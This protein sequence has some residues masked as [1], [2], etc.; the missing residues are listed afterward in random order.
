MI[1]YMLYEIIFVIMTLVVIFVGITIGIEALDDLK[2]AR[3]F[4]D[5]NKELK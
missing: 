1:H 4:D 2:S 3:E 5:K